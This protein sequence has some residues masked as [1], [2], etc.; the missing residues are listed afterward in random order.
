[1]TKPTKD[2]LELE[3]LVKALNQAPIQTLQIVSIEITSFKFIL[4]YDFSQGF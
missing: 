3:E 1:M 2:E 4:N